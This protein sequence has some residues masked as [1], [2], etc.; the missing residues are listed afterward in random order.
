M[1]R[2]PDAAADGSRRGGARGAAVHG[3]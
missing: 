2:V 1:T 3:R